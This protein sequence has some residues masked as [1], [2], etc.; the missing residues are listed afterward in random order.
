MSGK[1]QTTRPYHTLLEVYQA[2]K[3]PSP[4]IR[5]K[6]NLLP[7][8]IRD[9]ICFYIADN[10]KKEKKWGE[11]HVFDSLP[12]LEVAI[13]QVAL[14]SFDNLDAGLKKA[15]TEKIK[16]YAVSLGTVKKDSGKT[17]Y[18][19]TPEILIKCLDEVHDEEAKTPLPP[20]PRQSKSAFEVFFE[21][22]FRCDSRA[23]DRPSLGERR[24]GGL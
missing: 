12:H 5:D 6:F 1:I 19:Y 15:A 24:I 22:L 16:A 2:A 23:N 11:L 20:R 9:R 10:Q 17:E 21:E 18:H 8:K 3:K 7:Q 13:K 14:E 4:G